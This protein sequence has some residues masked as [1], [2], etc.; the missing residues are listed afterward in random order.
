MEPIDTRNAALEA[1]RK[2]KERRER[3]AYANAFSPLNNMVLGGIGRLVGMGISG[4]GQMSPVPW[5]REQIRAGRKVSEWADKTFPMSETARRGAEMK[6]EQEAPAW[7]QEEAPEGA[8]WLQRKASGLV[9]GLG[10]EAAAIGSVM[11]QDPEAGVAYLMDTTVRNAPTSVAAIGTYAINPA[12]GL[13]VSFGIESGALAQELAKEIEER[14][15][16]SSMREEA[17]IMLGAGAAASL[18]RVG[19]L[20]VNRAALRISKTS[21]IKNKSRFLKGVERRIQPFIEAG[22]EIPT[23]MAQEI[24]ANQAAK[25]G[26]DPDRNI[27]EGA[28]EAGLAAGPMSLGAGAMGSV[29]GSEA[30]DIPEV[31][32]AMIEDPEGTFSEVLNEAMPSYSPQE[33]DQQVIHL[34]SGAIHV[35]SQKSEYLKS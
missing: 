24:I 9:R 3:E 12:A 4:L 20:G 11:N 15:F 30:L 27:Y 19:A 10:Q 34:Q 26:W 14:G 32:Q 7:T 6:Q 22:K 33:G 21:A 16:D 13:A 35:L 8:S 25:S 28:I 18:D 31:E 2:E 23:E 17:A 5:R 1:L 29:R